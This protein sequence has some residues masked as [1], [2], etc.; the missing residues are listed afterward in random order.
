VHARSRALLPDAIQI[1]RR[2]FGDD[3]MV[4]SGPMCLFAEF[5]AV[6]DDFVKVRLTLAAVAMLRHQIETLV[7]V[8][9][10]PVD[11][12]GPLEPRL[13]HMARGVIPPDSTS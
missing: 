8:E 10:D 13:R 9:E 1:I 5:D 3:A 7:R 12:L 6:N 4:R 2:A 11:D